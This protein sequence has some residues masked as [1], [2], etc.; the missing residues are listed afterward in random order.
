MDELRGTRCQEEEEGSKNVLEEGG[1][2][3]PKSLCPR[4]GPTRFSQLH[5]SFFPTMVWEGLLR[6]LSAV[7]LRPWKGGGWEG[8]VR[9][10][11]CGGR[12]GGKEGWAEIEVLG[13]G[14]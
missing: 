13:G 2:G 9:N 10:A 1:E 5:I 8:E 11:K 4:N 12:D 14:A 3:G 6:W 7:L